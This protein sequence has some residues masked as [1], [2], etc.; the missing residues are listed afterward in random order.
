[1]EIVPFS[2]SGAGAV[3][4]LYGLSLIAYDGFIALTA[5]ILTGFIL[6]L[7]LFNLF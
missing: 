7:A 4:T 6:A 1:M 5:Y 2:A 3:I